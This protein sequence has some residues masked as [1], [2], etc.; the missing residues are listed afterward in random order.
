M[1]KVKSATFSHESREEMTK[2]GRYNPARKLIYRHK[3]R[4]L[5]V[6]I[7]AGDADSVDVY[8]EGNEIFV[9]SRNNS[10]GY[11][12]LEVFRDGV[13]LAETFFQGEAAI[14]ALGRGNLSP[15]STIRRLSEYI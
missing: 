2:A 15:L 14:D 8:R 1:R 12:G 3:H 11:V 13:V 5:A 7:S 4:T 6:T 10:L 9:L